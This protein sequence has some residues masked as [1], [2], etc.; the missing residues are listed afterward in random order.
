MTDNDEDPNALGLSAIIWLLFAIFAGV[1][2]A[3]LV[4]PVT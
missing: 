3:S 4:W 2:I 1:M